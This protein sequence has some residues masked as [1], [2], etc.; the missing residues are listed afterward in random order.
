MHRSKWQRSFLR[1]FLFE[2]EKACQLCVFSNVSSSG[3]YNII[4]A[5]FCSLL[6]TEEAVLGVLRLGVHGFNEAT[7][8]HLRGTQFA[9]RSICRRYKD[10]NG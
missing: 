9:C 4:G 1:L 5:Q 8:R 6:S 2:T 3:K 10:R 7:L